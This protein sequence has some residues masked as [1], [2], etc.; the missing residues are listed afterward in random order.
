MNLSLLKLDHIREAKKRK[1]N[2]ND[3][4][5]KAQ[6]LLIICVHELLNWM[7]YYFSV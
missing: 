5:Q 2:L 1:G 3:Y 4:R 7:V 6:N